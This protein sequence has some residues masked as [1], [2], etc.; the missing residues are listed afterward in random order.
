MTLAGGYDVKCTC[1]LESNS[2]DAAGG[3]VWTGVGGVLLTSA[4]L[5][6]SPACFCSLA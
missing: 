3:G 5:V 1:L 4:T 2:T 6:T